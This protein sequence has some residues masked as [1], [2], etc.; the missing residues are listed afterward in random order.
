MSILAEIIEH[1]KT[2]IASLDASSL[3]RLAESSPAPRNFLSALTP[4]LPG[5]GPGVRSSITEF[6]FYAAITAYT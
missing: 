3:R 1:K 5:E 6:M 2:E 4:L